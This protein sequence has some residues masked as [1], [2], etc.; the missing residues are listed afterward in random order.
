MAKEDIFKSQPKEK[1]INVEN[2]ILKRTWWGCVRS[3][4]HG[5]NW[6]LETSK[7]SMWMATLEVEEIISGIRISA[8]KTWRNTVMTAYGNNAATPSCAK[9]KDLSMMMR[10]ERSLT[11]WRPQQPQ[12]RERRN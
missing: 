7:A 1:S 5:K 2:G 8:K 3:R 12:E 4:R 9:I 6:Q 10:N 11:I